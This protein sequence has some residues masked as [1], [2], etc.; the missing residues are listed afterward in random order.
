MLSVFSSI[1]WDDNY[2]KIIQVIMLRECVSEFEIA[3]NI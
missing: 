2:S 3:G 1:N